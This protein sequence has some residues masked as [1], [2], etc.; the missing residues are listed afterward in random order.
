MLEIK[1]V[2]GFIAVAL[3][4]VG[5]IPYFRDILKGKTIPHVYSWI[6]WGFVTAVAFALQVSAGAGI[7]ALV[8]LTVVFMTVGVVI[9]SFYLHRSKF[10]ITFLDTLFLILGFV[11]LGI[12]LI[13]KDPVLSI[14]VATTTD[15]L[16]FVP[17]IR[18]TWKKPYSETL[19]TSIITTFRF[20]L[21]IFALQAY[22]IVTILYPIAWALGN[23]FFSAMIIY[24]RSV[25]KK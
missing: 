4:F 17:T 6:L 15:L 13:A 21:A 19:S 9:L 20:A 18:K 25:I 5:Y 14:V 8:T 23:A 16:A 3:V 10:D 22:S 7:G 1:N 11:S 2:I 12:W 24:R